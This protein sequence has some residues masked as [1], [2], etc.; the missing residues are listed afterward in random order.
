MK[1]GPTCAASGR[2]E[3]KVEKTEKGLMLE[4]SCGGWGERGQGLSQE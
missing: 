4:D 1:A 3:K 2:K